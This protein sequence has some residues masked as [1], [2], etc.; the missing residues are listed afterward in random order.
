MKEAFIEFLSGFEDLNRVKDDVF[1]AVGI[2]VT[3]VPSN[4]TTNEIKSIV[5][6]LAEAR[7]R[8]YNKLFQ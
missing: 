5:K 8:K 4:I 6:N 7:T 3:K 1:D 2:L